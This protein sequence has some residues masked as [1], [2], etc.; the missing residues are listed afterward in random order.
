[1]LFLYLLSSSFLP[2]S[3]FTSSILLLLP[4]V[5]AFGH[6]AVAL[7]VVAAAAVDVVVKFTTTH[8]MDI[9]GG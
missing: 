8:Y 6:S 5:A 1:M 4:T 7:A 9:N 2:S 3:P